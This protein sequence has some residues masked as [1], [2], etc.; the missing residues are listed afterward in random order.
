MTIFPVLLASDNPQFKD[1]PETW[2]NFNKL[3]ITLNPSSAPVQIPDELLPPGAVLEYSTKL[4]QDRGIY[5][6]IRE[7]SLVYR[8]SATTDELFR[9]YDKAFYSINWKILQKDDHFILAEGYGKSVISVAISDSR[10][11][12]LYK[13]KSLYN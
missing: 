5:F 1:S 2:L 4:N 13:K 10:I 12:I 6:D 7:V 8:I 9:F 11:K 3:N